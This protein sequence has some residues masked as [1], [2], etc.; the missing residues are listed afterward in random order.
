MIGLNIR[1]ESKMNK[2]LVCLAGL[3]VL[4]LPSF[5]KIVLPPVLSSNMVLQQERVCPIWGTAESGEKM[6]VAFDGQVVRT[7]ADALGRWA[8]TLSPMKADSNPKLLTIKGEKEKIELRNIVVGEVWLCG[9]QSNMQYSMR[10][11]KTF[12]PPAKG[13]DLGAEELKQPPHPM[14]RVFLSDRA[15]SWDSWQVASGESLPDISAAGYFFGKYIQQK[16]N[17]P[18]GIISAALGGQ[19]V[20]A[21]TSVNAYNEDSLY[22]QQLRRTSKIGGMEPGQWYNHLIVPL[23]PFALRGF[24]WYQGENNC[25]VK[26]QDYA[27]KYKL[28]VESWRRAFRVEDAPFYAVLLAPHTYS[29]GTVRNGIKLTPDYLPSFWQQQ[30][31]GVKSVSNSDI[32]CISDLVDDLKDIHPPYKWIVGE[33]LARLALNKTYGMKELIPTGPHIISAER[34]GKKLFLTFDNTGKGLKSRDGKPLDWFE[35]EDEGGTFHKAK[36]VILKSGKVALHYD[37]L[38]HPVGVRFAWNEDAMPNLVSSEGLPA[39]PFYL[40]SDSIR[41]K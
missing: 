30:I 9:G 34:K 40:K 39:F 22:R 7:Q 13:V 20:E 26:E 33:R 21:W 6:T 8:V 25:V 14:I 4:L 36:A 28:M 31:Q 2:K 37:A 15:Q 5:S 19:R 16:L 35:L 3:L 38:L 27:A 10:R 32:I 11:Y 24:L 29:K 23:E 18:V 41:K 12:A 17:V 1:E